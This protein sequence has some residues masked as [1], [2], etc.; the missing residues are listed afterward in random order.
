MQQVHCSSIILFFE[1]RQGADP[2]H[3]FDSKQLFILNNDAYLGF[4][5][6]SSLLTPKEFRLEGTVD[7]IIIPNSLLYVLL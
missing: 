5:L 1:V 2:L 4:S 3:S 6:Q 7:L